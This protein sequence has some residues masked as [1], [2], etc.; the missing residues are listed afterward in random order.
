[1][2]LTHLTIME[3]AAL[4]ERRELS[5]V[6]LVRAHLERIEKVNPLLNCFITSLPEQALY[7]AK[8]AERA[9][10]TGNYRGA[11]HGI[12]VA[13]KDLFET[14]GVR[15][16]AGST[17][18]REYVPEQ[19][20]AVV[21]RLE[22]AGAILL[23]KLNMHEWAMD[24]TNN[25]PHYGPCRNPWDHD[26]SPGG[27]SGGSGAALAAGLCLG[28][29]GSDTGGS[30]RIPAA[31]CGIVGLKPTA[32]HISRRGAIPLSWSLDHVG[33]MARTV[34]DVA[35]LLEVLSGHDRADPYSSDAATASLAGT[36]DGGISG[37]RLGYITSGFF[38][39]PKQAEPEVLQLVGRAAR[40]MEALGAEVE[41]IPL[42]QAR[43]ARR[44]NTCMLLSDAVSLH[45]ERLKENPDA[46]GADV[47]A[48][49]RLGERFSGADY[50]AARHEQ[51][52]FRREAMNLFDNF[53]LL[54]TPATATTAPLLDAHEDDAPVR[55]T[56]TSYT[57]PWNL[58]GF[59]ALSL[60]CGFTSQ[61]LP[62]GLQ[63][64]ARPWADARLLRA[65]QAYE[66]A[67][68]WHKRKAME[69]LL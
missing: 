50:G 20:A 37:W 36:I 35:L 23:G 52:I 63:L 44:A 9:I 3:A 18:L 53:D 2:E 29:V 51:T 33:P 30:V 38:N 24:V 7:H 67:T 55:P 4:V 13:I 15:T 1:M 60:P 61:G 64:I 11:L 66:Q 22:Q 65:G 68:S 17:F 14:R 41:E 47:L 45:R 58:A 43:T 12:P 49:L 56:L 32:G 28:S 48:S 69:Q 21:E 26:R 19:D 46:F 31:L 34:K 54:L 6:D 40:L 57:S 59:P 5:P 39:T 62:V 16:T 8:E 27:S 42:P 25:N 10:S